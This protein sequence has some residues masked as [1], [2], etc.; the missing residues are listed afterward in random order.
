[1]DRRI[2]ALMAVALM[3][4]VVVPMLSEDSDAAALDTTDMTVEAKGTCGTA[5]WAYSR[6]AD[7][8]SLRRL[9]GAFDTLSDSKWKLT[10][11]KLDNSEVP[12]S[13]ISD[14]SV[15]EI[16]QGSVDLYV[17]SGVT[18]SSGTMKGLGAVSV[19]FG[20]DMEIPAG[21]FKD[22]ARLATV[23]LEG[24]K[25]IGSGSFE[26]CTSLTTV[27][28]KKV[29]SI[30]RTAFKG[31]TKLTTFSATGS[32]VFK[33][34]NGILMSDNGATLYMCP[35]G[36]ADSVIDD[37]PSGVNKVYLDYA[38]VIYVVDEVDGLSGITF[39][40]S[41]KDPIAKAVSFS[42]L[43][44]KDGV[45]YRSVGGSLVI[46]YSLYKGWTVAG[47]SM[48][49]TGAD[50]TNASATTMTVKFTSSVA[51]VYPMGIN[52]LKYEDLAEIDS[53]GDWKVSVS[54]LDP[55]K[56]GLVKDV[57]ALKFVVT[58]YTGEGE[59]LIGDD[60]H[61]HGID[62]EFIG[63]KSSIGGMA[64]L[65]DL[66]IEADLEFGVDALAN[67]PSLK[68]VRADKV[69]KVGDSAFR[70][71]TN[72]QTVSFASCTEF[73]KYAFESCWSLETLSLGASDV[74]F[75]DDALR[76]CKSLGLLVVGMDT[77]V[78]GASGVPVLHYD[79]DGGDASFTV[80]GGQVIVVLEFSSKVE[81]ALEKDGERTEVQCYHKDTAIIPIHDEM[82]IWKKSGPSASQC[83][84][85]FDSGLGLDP[86]VSTVSWGG[87]TAPPA[88]PSKWGY[89][90]LYWTYD[91]KPFDFS[92]P[93]EDSIVLT[94]VWSK[95]NEV[96]STPIYLLAIFGAS[97]VAT[98]I[99]I[100][101]A[102][103]R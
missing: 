23:D 76:G 91:G 26:G 64:N 94:A 22:C 11:L 82:Y 69:T 33:A 71:C 1:M 78:S 83:M 84:V 62:S 74:S 30:D 6:D 102:K 97:V 4:I 5:T 13:E 3:A 80:V 81:Y 75:E 50:V 45:E 2:I 99:V 63:I 79:A 87:Q 25:S 12:S 85:V 46:D 103:K 15:S 100:A 31:C 51:K 21:M 92:T 39:D 86:V 27:D 58:G 77:V 24:V 34:H 61:Y 72:L 68:T 18:A 44:M 38:N 90:F 98:F 36:Y 17:A 47:D 65:T 8:N 57:D 7:T 101:M 49:S 55:S 41:I 93:V 10:E 66:T 56:K 19:S 59:G 32:T 95:N 29:A 20:T 35:T 70:Y 40:A 89:Q 73:G 9:S 42:T 54:G 48:L 28:V 37:L 67:C 16:I 96:D 60:V 53:F 14:Y 88:E 52:V 43:G